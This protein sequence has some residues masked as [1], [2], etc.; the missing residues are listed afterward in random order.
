MSASELQMTALPIQPASTRMVDSPAPVGGDLTVGPPAAH[1]STAVTCLAAIC[2]SCLT[3]A[4]AGFPLLTGGSMT[5]LLDV[6]SCAGGQHYHW[7]AVL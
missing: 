3:V 4:G 1:V 2:M 5:F 7:A 6:S